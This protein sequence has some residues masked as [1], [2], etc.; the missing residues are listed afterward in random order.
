MSIHHSKSISIKESQWFSPNHGQI[1][2]FIKKM[3]L[4]I[5]KNMLI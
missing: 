2:T 5:I 4:K 1:G 3:Y